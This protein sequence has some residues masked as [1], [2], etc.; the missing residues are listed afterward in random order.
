MSELDPRE[1]LQCS[2]SRLQIGSNS[3]K[4]DY[5]LKCFVDFYLLF[6]IS[7]NFWLIFSSSLKHFL[8]YRNR[9]NVFKNPEFSF[10]VSSLHLD[11]VGSL[12]SGSRSVYMEYTDPQHWLKVP[13]VRR[14]TRERQARGSCARAWP[15]GTRRPLVSPPNWPRSGTPNQSPYFSTW[16]FLVK[17]K[18]LVPSFAWLCRQICLVMDKLANTCILSFGQIDKFIQFGTNWRKTV[19]LGVRGIEATDN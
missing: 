19:L 10:Q 18:C 8:I 11:P 15:P 4:T 14:A 6:S 3:F 5:N 12:G 17:S 1:L 7:F 16:K 2:L 9:K 13:F